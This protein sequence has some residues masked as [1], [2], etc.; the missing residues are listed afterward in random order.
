MCGRTA[1]ALS[2]PCLSLACQYQDP[3]GSYQCPQW[4]DVDLYG[5]YEP[6]YNIAP[7][8]YCPVLVNNSKL[9]DNRQPKRVLTAMKWGLVPN[10]H[11]GNPMNF[12]LNTFNCR[13]E[14]CSY[15]RCYKP[16]IAQ[17]RRCVVVAEGYYEWKQP[18]S[19]SAKEPF[20][21]YFKQPEGI[22]MVT[23]EWDCE[24]KE[25]TLFQ[26]GRWK[27]PK[28]LTMAAIFDINKNAYTF[29]I[30][31]LAAP[32]HMAWLHDRVPMVLDG[33]DAV[34]AWLDP[35][36]DTKKLIDDFQFP[37]TLA[38]H[39]VTSKIGNVN[40][41]RMDCV[42]PVIK[43]ESKPKPTMM[44]TWLF[45]AKADEAGPSTSTST[46]SQPP[47]KPED[48]PA[49]QVKK[50]VGVQEAVVRVKGEPASQEKQETDV[51]EKQASAKQPET[52]TKVE[53][54]VEIKIKA[55]SLMQLKEE[56]GVEPKKRRLD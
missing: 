53:V 9:D 27:G 41:K 16:A 18:S 5:T 42:L 26:D 17:G 54:K 8:S 56:E 25:K 31:T 34:A 10:W 37:T 38:W 6:S 33:E 15:R 29:S 48:E 36:V 7:R 52:E 35:S 24:G 13:V 32:E 14:S 2:K 30:M 55:E 23:R 12:N 19:G 43:E 46:Q 47:L 45:G 39:Q 21:I 1:C 44:D 28:L 20:F 22:S 4:C 40:Y 49:V 51:P 11:Y 3:A 50:E